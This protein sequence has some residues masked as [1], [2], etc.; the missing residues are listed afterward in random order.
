MDTLVP[1]F[2]PFLNFF[3][4]PPPSKGSFFDGSS[5]SRGSGY[6]M[7][8][9]RLFFSV[10]YLYPTRVHVDDFGFGRF[11]PLLLFTCGA[12]SFYFDLNRQVAGCP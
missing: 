7:F 2:P 11:F 1:F 12:V 8:C 3:L 5:S 6:A 10:V 9:F 4:P